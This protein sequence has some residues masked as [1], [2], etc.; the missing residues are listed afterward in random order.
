MEQNSGALHLVLSW[1]ASGLAVFVT[2]KI[3]RGFEVSGFFS[4]CLAAL[5]IAVVNFLFWWLL[6]F[7]TL[8]LNILTLGLF[9]FVVNGIILKI[10]AALL[11]GFEL[12]SWFSAIIGAIILAISE[13]LLHYLLI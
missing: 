5:M 10:A 6:I 7:L 4:A 12:K 11:P 2:S 8:P 3:V 9:T 13:S 1:L